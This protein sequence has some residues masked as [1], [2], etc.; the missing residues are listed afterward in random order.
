MSAK[1]ESYNRRNYVRNNVLI[2]HISIQ[3][4]NVIIQ[5]NALIFRLPQLNMQTSFQGDYTF[6]TL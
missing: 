6:V 4:F 1:L 2:K 5:Q 3:S